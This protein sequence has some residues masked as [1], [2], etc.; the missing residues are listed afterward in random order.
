MITA[1]THDE[2]RPTCNN[3]WQKLELLYTKADSESVFYLTTCLSS[4]LSISQIPMF[5]EH[6]ENDSAFSLDISWF[7]CTW[8]KGFSFIVFMEDEN[9][10]FHWELIL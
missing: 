3:K 1:L 6:K 10:H 8:L 7:S 5:S 9:N 2:Q 4:V